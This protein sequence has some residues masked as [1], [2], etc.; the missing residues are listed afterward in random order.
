MR[1]LRLTDDELMPSRYVDALV[2]GREL[3][4]ELAQE[5]ARL[6]P[7]GLGNPAVELLLPGR[8]SRTAALPGTGNTFSARWRQGAPGRKPSGSARHTCGKN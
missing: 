1:D 4:L 8:I 7:F 2:C 5:L 3:I 6:E